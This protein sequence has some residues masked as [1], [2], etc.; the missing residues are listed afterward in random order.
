MLKCV[1]LFN[2]GFFSIC[3][4]AFMN[5][6]G[7]HLCRFAWHKNL[8]LQGI[9]FFGRKFVHLNTPGGWKVV[10]KIVFFW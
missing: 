5:F 6:P 3:W 9:R 10:G 7:L 1:E 8:K 2:A 4:E